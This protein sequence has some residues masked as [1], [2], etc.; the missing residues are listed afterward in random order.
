MTLRKIIFTLTFSATSFAW[1]NAP[2]VDLSQGP[3]QPPQQ[4][5]TP[6]SQPVSQQPLVMQP[7]SIPI[8]QQP[9]SL[10]DEVTQLR[11]Q[12]VNIIQMN[13][14][15]RIDTLQQQVQ[16]LQ[17]Q[18]EVQQHDLQMMQQQ[19]KSFYQDLDQ[20]L[21]QIKTNPANS[22]PT[23]ETSATP[24]TSA[25]NSVPPITDQ[26]AYQNAFVLLENKKF[27]QAEIFLKNYLKEY[28]N[29]QY[30]ANAHYWLGEIYVL[31]DKTQLASQEFQTV[32]N[33]YPQD[34]K[35]AD[36]ML[37]LAFIHENTGKRAQARQELR[38]ILKQYP[39]TSA[40]QLASMRLKSLE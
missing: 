29:G 10:E 9:M 13:Y 20:R 15:A 26:A 21:S 19:Q 5:S 1:A 30:A 32:I 12:M 40:A 3:A 6:Q 2:V 4:L 8:Q 14:P 7:P 24:N 35:V 17:G 28:P 36:A 16:Q 31:N 18:I 38:K 37:K 11:Q 23:A 39:G 22:D 34:Q 25:A 33:K 27:D